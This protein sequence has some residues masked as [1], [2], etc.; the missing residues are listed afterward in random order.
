MEH[1]CMSCGSYEF[2]IAYADEAYVYAIRC[3]KC[4]RH[5]LNFAATG[6]EP[7]QYEADTMIAKPPPTGRR[8]RSVH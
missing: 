3:A 1:C 5:L 6:D 4:D 8:I 2:K 7:H